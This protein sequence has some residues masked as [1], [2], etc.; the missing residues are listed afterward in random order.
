MPGSPLS[1]HAHPPEA[2]HAAGERK[3]WRDKALHAVLA[4]LLNSCFTMLAR[5]TEVRARRAA[6]CCLLP[7]SA[8]DTSCCH[9]ALNRRLVPGLHAGKPVPYA[10]HAPPPP[11]PQAESRVR[12]LQLVSVAAEAAGDA[13]RPH[14]GAIAAALPQV[15]E[16]ASAL[17]R[18]ANADIGA[19]ARLHSALMAVMTHLVNR[20]RGAALEDPGLQGV[21]FPLL[22]Y[23]TDPAS[24]EADVLLEEALKLW[25]AR[26]R[27]EG[28][29]GAGAGE[30]E[31]VWTAAATPRA[32]AVFDV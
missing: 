6:C 9:A 19:V 30:G 14:L 29:Q 3:E 27:G 23:A 20:L 17:S 18:R 25:Q 7:G 4:E 13:L 26:G 21:L 16:A 12:L 1:P 31:A 22:H 10:P 11:A 28:V 8:T 24:P 2:V 15:W 32:R 5:L